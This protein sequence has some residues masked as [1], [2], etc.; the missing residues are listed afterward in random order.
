MPGEPRRSRLISL[1]PFVAGLLIGLAIG[2]PL[3]H[4]VVQ[5]VSQQASAAT[6]PSP[7]SEAASATS[8]PTASASPSAPPA[9]SPSSSASAAPS[10]G[11]LPPVAAPLCPALAAGQPSLD[12]L[13]PPPTGYRAEAAL[14]WLG[15]G[16]STLP[17]GEAG[18]PVQVDR[19]WLLAISY[20]CP[21]GTVGLS[22]GTMLSVRETAPTSLTLGSA[23]GDAGGAIVDGAGGAAFSAGT[24][25]LEVVAPAACLWHVA[26]YPAQS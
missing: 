16:T 1:G 22:P 15:C 4:A 24:E 3:A 7:P 25:Q 9:S 6:S 17:P 26:L 19:A 18:T 2:V 8:V 20:T 5:L 11:G 14:G 10:P 23:S 13:Q 21:L 12:A